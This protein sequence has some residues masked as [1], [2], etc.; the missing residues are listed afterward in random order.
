MHQEMKDGGRLLPA[1]KII[2]M[3]VNLII[4]PGG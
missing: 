1:M 2:K 4:L 3:I